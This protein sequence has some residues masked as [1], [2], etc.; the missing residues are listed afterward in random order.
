MSKCTIA[1]SRGYTDNVGIELDQCWLNGLKSWGHVRKM[2][3]E[4]VFGGKGSDKFE[5]E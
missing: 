4:D 5:G 2:H 3:G 1:S